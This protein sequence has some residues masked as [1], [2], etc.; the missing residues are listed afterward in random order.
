VGGGLV[1]VSALRTV[2]LVPHPERPEAMELARHAAAWL[3]EI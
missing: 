1:S 3:Q 2:G